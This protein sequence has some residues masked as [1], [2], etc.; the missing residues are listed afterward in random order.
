MKAS[1]RTLNSGNAGEGVFSG[2]GLGK[3]AQRALVNRGIDTLRQLSKFTLHEILNLH[4]IGKSA[5]PILKQTLRSA[6]LS[7]KTEK[8]DPSVS[9]K[10]AGTVDA[11]LAVLPSNARSTLSV[12]RKAIKASAPGAEEKINYGVPFYRLNGH[13]T[14]FVYTRSHCSL[15]TMS[16]DVI[17]KF[18]RELKPYKISGT[19]IHFD[20][21]KPLSPAL[22]KKIIKARIKENTSKAEIKKAK[23]KSQKAKKVKKTKAKK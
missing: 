17:R 3:P 10:N 13:L 6:G 7:F 21:D 4:G 19:T 11:Y 23:G 22:V 5:I 9:K 14:A 2:I 18:E 20:H 8:D 15:V 1:K 12:V 16:Y